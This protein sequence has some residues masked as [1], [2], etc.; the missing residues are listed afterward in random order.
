M[1]SGK[2]KKVVVAV[3]GGFD[4]IHIG[5]V[6]MF[7]EAKKLGTHLLVIINNDNWLRQK[8]QHIFMSDK[9]RK[10]VIESLKPVDMVVLTEHKKN[11][12]DMSVCAE[13]VKYK[14][15]IFA[16]GGDRK[17][18]NI[19]E[20][21]VCNEIGCKMVFGVGK[22][23]KVQSSSW[24][25][26]KYVKKVT[27]K[28]ENR[29][30][31]KFEVYVD[32]SNHKVKK[33]TVAPGAKLSLQSHKHRAEHWVVVKG[34]ATIVN[35]KK[36]M[37]LTENESTYIPKGVKHQLGNKGK[38][39]LEIIEVQTGDYFGEDDIIRYEDQYGR[40]SGVAAA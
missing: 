39:N 21:P 18:G 2:K 26:E 1:K 32:D 4:P 34:V 15:D 8:K 29:P 25:L 13:L 23:G 33:L 27:D 5:H 19:P 36:T 17:K 28:S 7:E 31:G 9:E 12:S 22:G 20:V 37:T 10:E 14:P 38:K 30:W 11:P 35:G 16:N 40:P 6:R 24:L 3:S